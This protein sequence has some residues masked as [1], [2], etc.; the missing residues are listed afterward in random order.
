MHPRLKHSLATLALVVVFGCSNDATSPSQNTGASAPA[1]PSSSTMTF[2]LEFPA[3]DQ[4]NV[5]DDEIRAGTPGAATLAAAGD[6]QNWINAFVRATYIVLTTY[7]YLEEPAAAFALAIHSV[8]QRQDDGSFLWTYIFVDQK[9]DIE[10]EIFLYGLEGDEAV[11]WRLEVSSDDPALP[12][13]HFVWFTGESSKSDRSGYWQFY[14][15]VDPTNGTETARIDWQEQPGDKRLT[16]T[17]NGSGL[18]N[19]GD[20]LDFHHT[21]AQSTIEYTDASAGATSD[22]T[23][24]PDGS[25]SLA[26]PDY[27]GGAQACW[28]AHQ[29]DAACE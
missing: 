9:A 19:E 21:R 26:V 1:L 14:A 2:D 23:W 15:P 10:Y 25:G 24:Y 4:A 6:R 7:D 18:P 5:S 11:S 28:D 3:S 16:I 27:N 8:P 12:L 29:L 22:I 20:V 17:V 13:D